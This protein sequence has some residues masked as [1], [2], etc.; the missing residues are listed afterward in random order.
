MI[1]MEIQHVDG[2]GDVHGDK[3]GDVYGDGDIESAMFPA[4]HINVIT[5]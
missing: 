4:I 3:N 2:D 5:I 1:V